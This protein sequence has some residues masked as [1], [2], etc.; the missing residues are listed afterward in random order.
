MH[1]NARRNSAESRT[2]HQHTPFSKMSTKCTMWGDETYNGSYRPR[3][4]DAGGSGEPMCGY[5]PHATNKE[6]AM[7]TCMSC[8]EMDKICS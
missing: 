8:R 2:K 7:E 5:N 3:L 4:V 1:N 6:R